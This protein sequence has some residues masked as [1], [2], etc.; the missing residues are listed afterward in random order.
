[1]LVSGARDTARSSGTKP[2]RLLIIS[3]SESTGSFNRSLARVAAAA[4]AAAAARRAP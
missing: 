1:M 2:I 3:G 4:A